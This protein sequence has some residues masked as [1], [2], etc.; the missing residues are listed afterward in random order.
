MASRQRRYLGLAREEEAEPGPARG[1]PRERWATSR[2]PG[3]PNPPNGRG[4]TGDDGSGLNWSNVTVRALAVTCLAPLPSTPAMGTSL[5]FSILGPLAVEQDGAPIAISGRRQR[6]LL[7]RLL[8]ARGRSVAPARLIDDLWGGEPPPS[9]TNTLQTYVS[10][11]RRAFGDKEQAVL[12]R[13]AGGYRLA[14][15]P[16]ALD[17]DRFEELVRQAEKAPPSRGPHPARR[18]A[19]P[20]A[21]TGAARRGRRA[22]RPGRERA[23]GGAAPRRR[24]GSL[25]APARRRPPRRSRAGPRGRG[26]RAAPAAKGSRRCWP[27]PCTGAGD[28]PTRCAPSPARGPTSPTSWVST[29]GRS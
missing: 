15:E 1:R 16:G 3:A 7:L 12:V 18:G 29:P 2:R 24:R 27:R 17:I 4:R 22:L 25:P 8:L 9:A 21:R 13:D 11:L 23:A 10:L 6:A 19:R 5:R 14:L 26:G 20:V 28:R